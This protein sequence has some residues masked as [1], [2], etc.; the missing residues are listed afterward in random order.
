MKYP[1]KIN[2]IIFY[3]M[4]YLFLFSFFGG[5]LTYVLAKICGV[6]FK[7]GSYN[8]PSNGHLLVVAG[9]VLGGAIGV[10]FGASLFATGNYLQPV[11]IFMR[12]L[13]A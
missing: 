10:G 9:A 13:M 11:Y 1:V 5:S 4:L 3:R 2:G 12:K 7:G 8:T 6:S